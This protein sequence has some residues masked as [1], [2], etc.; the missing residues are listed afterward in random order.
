MS[1][2]PEGTLGDAVGVLIFT[3]VCL[4]TNILLLWLFWI[5]N[6][7]FSCAFFLSAPRPEHLLVTTGVFD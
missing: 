2:L 1:Q 7:R 5:N 6:E 3:F 4:I